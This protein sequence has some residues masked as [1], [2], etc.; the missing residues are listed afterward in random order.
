MNPTDFHTRDHGSSDKTI[1]PAAPNSAT[2][3]NGPAIIQRV[4]DGAHASIDRLQRGVNQ[5]VEQA[6]ET[7]GEWSA[8][9]R[10]TVREHPLAALG[11][12]FVLGAVFARLMR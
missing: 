10:V 5:G 7:A 3:G 12:A 6:R 1:A 11:G 4:A 2:P 9:L 8:S